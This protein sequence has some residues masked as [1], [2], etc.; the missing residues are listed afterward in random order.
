MLVPVTSLYHATPT[1]SAIEKVRLLSPSLFSL[2]L[3]VTFTLNSAFILQLVSPVSFRFYFDGMYYLS[4]YFSANLSHSAPVLSWHSEPR[5]Y[6]T[7]NILI[8][9]DLPSLSH[10]FYGFTLGSCI[11]G[12][13]FIFMLL[14]L[15]PLALFSDLEPIPTCF[16]TST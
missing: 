3:F 12:F 5:V 9:L 2:P 7:S 1:R 4:P 10:M 14:N 6:L 8:F 13:I 11:Y 15:I 16:L